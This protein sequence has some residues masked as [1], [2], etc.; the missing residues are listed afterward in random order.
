MCTYAQSLQIMKCF[1]QNQR[2]HRLVEGLY[3]RTFQV[4]VHAVSLSSWTY[5]L[6]V[7]S[8]FLKD[9]LWF[10]FSRFKGVSSV[11]YF[12]HFGPPGGRVAHSGRP[13]LR[14]YITH[15]AITDFDCIP[16]EDFV[17]YGLKGFFI[18]DSKECFTDVRRNSLTKWG[19]VPN[20]DSV[21]LS[22]Q[23]CGFWV[24]LVGGGTSVGGCG[25]FCRGL[26]DTMVP[27]G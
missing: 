15:A 13:S 10:P 3:M 14:H 9:A 16:V 1:S 27:H 2:L 8:L 22:S 4:M 24:E 25:R 19:I 23:V 5:L 6:I 17:T 18:Y 26:A 12:L 11:F 20:D 21:V 7:L